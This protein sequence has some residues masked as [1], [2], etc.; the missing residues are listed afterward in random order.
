MAGSG[1]KGYPGTK[2]ASGPKPYIHNPEMQAPRPAL[3]IF[4]RGTFCVA[5]ARR[6]V[7]LLATSGAICLQ[8]E[9]SEIHFRNITF[10]PLP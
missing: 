10:T 2:G 9:G 1:R 4:S 6:R 7:I 5:A 3:G 8:S